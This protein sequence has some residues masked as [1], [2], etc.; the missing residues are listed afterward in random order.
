[1][2]KF[3]FATLCEKLENWFD[4]YS[5]EL[6]TLAFYSL[7]GF[8][9]L[10]FLPQ[11]YLVF[12]AT[13]L[14]LLNIT[15]NERLLFVLKILSL[16]VLIYI[17]IKACRGY[18]LSYFRMMTY[19]FVLIFYSYFR[20]QAL[21]TN[22]YI[23]KPN[24]EIIGY[25]DLIIICFMGALVI[26]FIAIISKFV[27]MQIQTIYFWYF[28]K[29][30]NDNC[31]IDN[32]NFIK[33]APL[34]NPK[35]DLFSY[36]DFA[37][38]IAKRINSM[39][40]DTPCSLGIISE[41]GAG[42]STAINFIIY[43]LDNT[44]HIIIRY[45]P[46]HSFSPKRIQEDFYNHLS[47][48]LKEYNSIFSTIFVD[49]MKGAGIVGRNNT[50]QILLNLYKVWDKEGKSIRINN[51]I[52]N[53]SNRVVVVIEDLDR[54]LAEEII[55]LFKIID[56]NS[57]SNN[58]IFITAYDK[59][60][61][62]KILDYKYMH[63][64]SMFS[65][66]FFNWEEYLPK[67]N[68]IKITE[69][70]IKTT[71]DRIKIESITQSYGSLIRQHQNIIRFYIKT[72]RDAKR[73]LNIF[74]DAFITKKDA[75]NF[76]DLF[77]I[78]LIRYKYPNEFGKLA[79]KHYIIEQHVNG[80]NKFIISNMSFD[81][82]ALEIV[83]R[84]LFNN[85]RDIDF[86]S[87]NNKNAFNSYF[88]YYKDRIEVDKLRNLFELQLSET[89][90]Q[91]LTW[92]KEKKLAQVLEYFNEVNI[93]SFKNIQTIYNYIDI[94]LCIK[95]EYNLDIR[96]HINMFFLKYDCNE[97]CKKYNINP[98]DFKSEFSI[99]L[100]GQPGEYPYSL[101]RELIINIIDKGEGEYL[102]T[103]AELQAIAKYHVQ[104]YID[105]KPTIKQD[106]EIEL[107]YENIDSL[108]MPN[109]TI[110]L[111]SEVCTLIKDFIIEHPDFY[112]KNFV[113]NGMVTSSK[114]WFMLACE[115]F[116]KQIFGTEA[117]FNKFI[118]NN[119]NNNEDI[120][121]VRNFWKIYKLNDFKPI[122]FQNM[123]YTYEEVKANKLQ[124]LAEEAEKIKLIGVEVERIY[125]S[126]SLNSEKI[127]K[128]NIQSGEL[129]KIELYIR[130]RGRVNDTIKRHLYNLSKE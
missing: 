38:N 43:Y 21:I 30:T 79:N 82:P 113:R 13:I 48:K 92:S 127:E 52:K 90:D 49:Y 54:L 110:N 94:L 105:N 87:I 114:D 3:K 63:E 55:E 125:I 71:E 103:K 74:I 8:C 81:N 40:K 7:F 10:L 119:L 39:P 14:P 75:I 64:E 31:K 106:L 36:K 42:K 76:D 130:E 9:C 56:N 108:E 6:K 25:I 101:I 5:Y 104:N 97:I 51:A 124:K 77:L 15:D 123:G 86:L 78:T 2:L 37:E 68:Q 95:T 84:K 65:D 59:E 33:D 4:I 50:I 47:S 22:E 122:E 24:N 121:L 126:S 41:W 28:K 16:V 45:N 60:H 1:M 120:E 117:A 93:L 70:L 67:I 116:W 128:I 80:R 18:R 19:F 35:D 129:D 46:R 17:S 89:K 96:E 62:N 27:I 83:L 107:L 73:F 88:N 66:K 69:Y 112:I 118:N 57:L 44:K 111:N 58:I 102:F 29:P 23:F 115:P 61:I 12:D 91:L 99:K 72:I 11:I 53:L 32:Y 109:R 20:Y 34:T 100:K 85:D 26:P 98:D